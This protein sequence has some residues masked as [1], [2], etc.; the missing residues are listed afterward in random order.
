MLAYCPTRQYQR[1]NRGIDLRR[2]SA[3]LQSKQRFWDTLTNL[4]PKPGDGRMELHQSS[5]QCIRWHV[6]RGASSL[7]VV[8]RH[9]SQSRMGLVSRAN[10]I[11]L[12]I[13]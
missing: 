4:E 13:R 1:Q 6:Y 12:C 9:A 10:R 2:V 5:V 8:A 7:K 11:H 3:S